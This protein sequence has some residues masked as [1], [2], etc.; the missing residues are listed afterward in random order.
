MKIIT[1]L[2]LVHISQSW[3]RHY[4]KIDRGNVEEEPTSTSAS[5]SS[6]IDEN[7]LTFDKI[8]Y[9]CTPP[10]FPT[11]PFGGG[12]TSGSGASLSKYLTICF[13]VGR[14]SGLSFEQIRPNLIETTT[15]VSSNS[16]PNLGSTTPKTAPTLHCSH[17]QSTRISSSGRALGS[18]GLLPQITSNKSPPNANTSELVVGFPVR[19]SSGAK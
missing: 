2:L 8:G 6:P 14:A 9:E 1:I 17:T 13:I 15:S 18:M 4:R 3:N 12:T 11:S 19:V 16:P 7:V 10:L 5:T